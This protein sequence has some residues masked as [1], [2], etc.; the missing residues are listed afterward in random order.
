[1]AI[2]YD[3]LMAWRWEDVRQSYAKRDTMLYALGLGLGAEPTNAAELG[4]V[5]ERNLQVLPTFAAVLAP[6]RTWWRETGQ[7]DFSKVVHGEQSLRVHRLPAP[8]GEVIGSTRLAGIIDKGRGRG[9]LLYT[10]RTLLDAG[11]GT[12]LATLTSTSFARGDGGFG[13][14]AGPIKAVHEMPTRPPDVCT[15]SR[16]LPQAALIYRLSGDYNVL[17]ADPEAASKAG[18]ERPILQGLCTFGI[19]GW[20]VLRAA[21]AGD[22]KRLTAIQV[23]FSSPVYPGETLRTEIWIDDVVSFRTVVV[24]RDVV[25]LSNGR[26]EVAPAA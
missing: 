14:P 4:F 11:D 22:P 7:V 25:A 10:E 5:Y 21:C 15:D 23:R 1:M 18:Y 13:G 19:A 20:A 16:T 17:H 24:G 9:A 26:A 8:D 12:T 6:P 2:D 3:K